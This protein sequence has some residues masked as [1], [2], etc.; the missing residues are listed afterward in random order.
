MGLSGKLLI[1]QN[2][3]KLTLFL[4]SRSSCVQR[5]IE[6]GPST[7]EV[8]LVNLILL[9]ESS[10]KNMKNDATFVRMRIDDH[11]GDAKMSK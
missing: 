10:W 2:Y 3:E 7:L 1:R 6:A 8:I 5:L 9:F 11:F 4:K